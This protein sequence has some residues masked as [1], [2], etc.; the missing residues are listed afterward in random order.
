MKLKRINGYS[1]FYEYLQ[2][3][4]N[5][6]NE[7]L[8]NDTF[9]TRGIPKMADLNTDNEVAHINNVTILMNTI[10]EDETMP[11]ISSTRKP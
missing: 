3:M 6:M 10:L 2:L 1:E 5:S 9:I 7:C 8:K 11:P 4:L